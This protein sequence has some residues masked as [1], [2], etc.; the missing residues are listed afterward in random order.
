MKSLSTP[1]PT[2]G[3]IYDHVFV[4]PIRNYKRTYRCDAQPTRAVSEAGGSKRC[5]SMRPNPVRDFLR[6]TWI[7][8]ER[9]FG[10]K[11][12]KKQGNLFSTG[13][14]YRPDSRT[15]RSSWQM[16]NTKPCSDLSRK[17]SE[18]DCSK[19]IGM[20]QREPHSPSSVDTPT[21][22][23]RSNS[24][25]TGLASEPQTMAIQALR[26]YSGALLTGTTT[27]GY[28][29]NSMFDIIPQSNSLKRLWNSNSSILHHTIAFWTLPV[30]TAQGTDHQSPKT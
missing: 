7:R 13:S 27:S 2:Y 18:S 16:A 12:T 20:S 3:I 25:P 23:T 26:A 10:P 22:S 1:R 28:I 19:V 30:G 5:T 11:G 17:W 15:T 14:S 6:R 9:L 21:P 4:R 24:Q 29:A 8:V